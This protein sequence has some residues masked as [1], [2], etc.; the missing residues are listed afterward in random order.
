MSLKIP[1]NHL[2]EWIS[3][4][5][6]ECMQS[7]IE[8]RSLLKMFRSYYY[9][10]TSDGSVAVYNRCYPHVERL[11]AFLFSPTDVRFH[12]E[13][14]H[15]EGEEIEAQANAASRKLNRLFHQKNLDQCF[16]SAVNGALIDGVNILKCAKG[17][18][19]PEGWVIRPS[20]FGVLREDIE[21]LDRQEAFVMS[22]YMTP[23]AFRRSI[24]ER[25]DRERIVAQ[26][27]ASA[28]EKTE[29][30]FTEDYFHQIIVGGTQP[31][32]TTTSSG[33]GMVG[34]VGVPQPVLDAKVARSLVRLDELWVQDRERQDY[35]TLRMVRGCNIVVEGKERRRNLCGLADMLGK[36]ND[37]RGFHP[38]VKVSPNEVQGYFWGM[39]EVAAIYRLQ[40]D[41]NEQVRSLTRLRR[42][43]ADP[44]R[45]AVGFAGLNLEKYKAFNRPRGFISEENPNA[46][47]EEH[48]PD[49]PQEFFAWLDKTMQFFDDVAGF[50]PIMQGQGEQ[51]VRSQ[52]QAAMLARNSSPRMRDRA[53]LVERQC[54]EWGEF[55]FRMMQAQEAEVLEE[56]V[57]PAN[58]Q[59]L[60]KNLPDDMKV[61]VDSHSSSPVYAEDNM[62][63]A[64]GLAKSGAIDGADL[65]MLTHPQHEDIL[66]ARAR[67]REAAHAQLIK[68]H[69]ELLLHGKGKK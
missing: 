44:P 28:T 38:F 43:K 15:S 63:L 59:F 54:A 41:L 66:I 50:T 7:S 25:D 46:K 33:S 61:S 62:K 4:I 56:K 47:M 69:P 42:L 24:W 32:S 31:V 65:L 12:I 64:F 16:S 3:E 8:R 55:V 10:G 27:E 49:I 53:L 29:D 9:T 37:F 21:E 22:T 57:G 18:D 5:C 11:G 36:D 14:D 48:A 51:G 1:Q 13:F 17:H 58:V 20:F 60:L 6:Q 40:D 2:E 68:Q 67:A 39:S 34:I 30:E 23:S 52:Q 19:G 35:T 26:V 45:S